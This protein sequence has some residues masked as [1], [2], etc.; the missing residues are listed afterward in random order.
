[1]KIYLIFALAVIVFSQGKV[2]AQIQKSVSEKPSESASPCPNFPMPVIKPDVSFDKNNSSVI[3]IDNQ[4]D[5]KLIIVNPC[6]SATEQKSDFLNPAEE[7]KPN[8]N[9]TPQP[10]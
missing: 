8:F 5:Y 7:I 4:I 6:L 2:S 9:F 1:M 10:K 3:K